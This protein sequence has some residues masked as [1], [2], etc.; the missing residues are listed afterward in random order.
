MDKTAIC[1]SLQSKRALALKG[2]KYQRR[3]GHDRVCYNKNGSEKLPLIVRKFENA[4]CIKDL[5]HYLCN[6]KSS[7]T[8]W[9]TER[10][11]R[12][13]LLKEKWLAKTGMYFKY[14]ISI[15]LTTRV[16]IGG[17]YTSICCQT[18]P[19]TCDNLTSSA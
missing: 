13:S 19:V 8:A 10:L 7:T 11:F 2:E 18:P 16:L 9:V 17:M 4:S 15:L 14:W 1:Y 3:R 6:F 5:Q 12:E